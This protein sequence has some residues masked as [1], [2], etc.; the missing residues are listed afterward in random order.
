MARVLAP[1]GRVAIGDV[2]RD[3][4]VVKVL[5]RLLRGLRRSHARIL[6]SAELSGYL[7]AA[8][9]SQAGSRGL[10]RG[11]YVIFLARK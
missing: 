10:R 5:D 6:S 8:G 4:L 9:L 1:G 11:G 2:N 7:G 3:R